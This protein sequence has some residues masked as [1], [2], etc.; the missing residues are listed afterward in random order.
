MR[1]DNQTVMQYDREFHKLSRFAKSLVTTEK[2]KAKRFVNSLKMSLQKDPS[3][4]DLLVELGVLLALGVLKCLS[5]LVRVKLSLCNF[6]YPGCAKLVL[7]RYEG[8]MSPS[9]T[10]IH[11]HM[12]FHRVFPYMQFCLYGLCSE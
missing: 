4:V 2:D 8:Y 6:S 10:R 12:G 1:Q 5:D 3:V 7:W 11:I 9:G